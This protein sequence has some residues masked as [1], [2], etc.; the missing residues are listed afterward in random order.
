MTTPTRITSGFTQAA[1]YQPLGDIGIPDPF[2]YATFEDDFIPYNAALYTVTA[3]SGSVAATTANGSDGR[4]LLTTG[5]TAGSFAE[6]QLTSAAFQYTSGKK[7]AFL[8]R[9]QVAN[10]TTSAFIAGL[11][12]TSATPFTS[13]A[14]GIYISKSAASTNVVVTAVTGGTTI[15]TATLSGL[16]TN[17]TD[18][19]LAFEVDRSGNIKVWAGANL[20][21][22]KRENTASLGPNIAINRTSL[23]G[24]ITSVLLNPTIAV[25]N[26]ATAA[27]MTG[28][29]DFLFAAQ[30]R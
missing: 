9:L 21:G 27:A 8:C 23:T 1:K 15:G 10:I 19:D 20:E 13:I 24:S 25:S 7:L 14:D 29:A 17:N 18:I 28:V 3:A 2:F 16:L 6:M 30:E 26:G 12:A 11:I 5:A 4:I 22:Y